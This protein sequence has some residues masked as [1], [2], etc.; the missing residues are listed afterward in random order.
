MDKNLQKIIASLPAL[1]LPAAFADINIADFE[2][3]LAGN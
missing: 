3:T 1:A 2:N